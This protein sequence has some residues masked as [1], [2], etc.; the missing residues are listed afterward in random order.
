MSWKDNYRYW[1][2]NAPQHVIDEIHT[3][4]DE[5]K[6]FAFTGDLAFGTAGVRGIMG[7]G[8]AVLNE[9]LMAKYAL[10][11]GKHL[12]HKYGK[13]AVRKG[14]IVAHDNRR[15]NILYSETVAE[16][17][18]ALGIPVF[19]F[20]DNKLQPTPL[21]SFVVSKTDYVG[22]INITASHN[23]PEYSGFKVYDHAGS[24]L[25]PDDTNDIVKYAQEDINIFE[26]EK[27]SKNIKH[28]SDTPIEEYIDRILTYVPFVK[29][30]EPK[31]LKVVFTAQH[32]T[33]GPIATTLMNKMK[34]NY[35]LVEEQMIEDPDF[36]NTESANPQDPASFI[37]A[38]EL[39]NKVDADVLFSTDP[40]ADRFGIEV[41]HKGEWVHIDGN[42]LPL[43][44]LYYKLKVLKEMDYLHHEDFI[45]KSVVTSK[46][47][48]ILAHKFGIKNY[49]SL[50]GFKWII[51]E[52]H[53]H[54]MQGN[55]CL[56]AW[57]ESYGSTVRSFTRD[58]DSFQ[59]LVQVIEIAEIKKQKG[60]TLVDALEEI[61]E[62]I[63]YWYSPQVQF[64]FS[65]INAMNDMNAIVEKARGFKEG[66]KIAGFE[67]TEVIDFAEG[68]KG[69]PKDNFVQIVL[70]E[71][72]RVTVRPSG[73]EPVLRVYFDIVSESHAR[74]KEIFE[75]LKE[76]FE[77]L[78][79]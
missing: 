9:F 7:Y 59:A 16:V 60:K 22:G 58:K 36:S 74:S 64:K 70:D 37:K 24:Q 50:T 20:K 51:A 47:A 26:I 57:E 11:Y 46:A 8:T 4:T 39:G 53:K 17:L 3:Y 15:N 18:S 2:E 65:G 66:Q 73:T 33:A 62:I 25:L 45:V 13:L 34:V 56:F 10:A 29:Y 38:R 35:H 77:A 49:N 19:F 72:F 41:K 28:L 40:D 12:I 71:D 21:L 54:E 27:S 52:V 61:Y 44:Q 30:D 55:E 76:Y 42:Q 14:V 43:I 23:P 6:E 67:I 69:L 68:Y 78:R 79:N 5:Q 48:E 1:I 32:G 75:Q 63:G 31:D